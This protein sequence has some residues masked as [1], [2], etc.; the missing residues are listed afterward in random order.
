MRLRSLWSLPMLSLVALMGTGCL[1]T[2]DQVCAENARYIDGCLEHWEALWPDFGYDGVRDVNS[3]AGQ[4]GDTYPGGPAEE[5][6]ERCK[7][8]YEAAMFFSHPETARTVR[9]GCSEDLQALAES[10]GCDDYQPTEVSDGIDPT[11]GDNGV[12]PRP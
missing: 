3:E 5:Y 4:A 7:A 8:R 2:C 1:D 11:E 10:V 12:P 6:D 9:I